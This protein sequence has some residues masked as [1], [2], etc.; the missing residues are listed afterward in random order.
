MTQLLSE[1]RTAKVGWEE[2]QDRRAREGVWKGERE[3]E[4]GGKE[5]PRP[6]GRSVGARAFTEQDRA[7]ARA[8]VCVLVYASAKNY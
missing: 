6:F 5:T 4:G 2:A 7:R 1:W 3:T 8:R